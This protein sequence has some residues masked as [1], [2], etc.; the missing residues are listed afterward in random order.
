MGGG[1]IHL[2][3]GAKW[4]NQDLEMR[5]NLV[6]AM[7]KLFF[8]YVQRIYSLR[9]N[10]HCVK[11]SKQQK[12]GILSEGNE[13]SSIVFERNDP[14]S[15]YTPCFICISRLAIRSLSGGDVVSIYRV[16]WFLLWKGSSTQN[17]WQKLERVIIVQIRG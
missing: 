4:Q 13:R 11:G 5:I 7:S 10:L 12:G 16:G 8:N 1:D 15:I 14:W 6:S 2:E 3:V 9:T 17:R